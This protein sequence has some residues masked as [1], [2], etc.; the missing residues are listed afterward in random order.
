MFDRVWIVRHGETEWNLLRR[1][2]GQLDSPLTDRGRCQA[3]SAATQIPV[4]F[5]DGLFSSPL[6]RGLDTARVIAET[7]DLEITVIEELA[8]VHHGRFAGLTNAEIEARFPGELSRREL[9]KYCWQFPDGESYEQAAG[10]AARALRRISTIGV[11]RPILVTHEMIGRMLL[12]ELLD[13]HPDRAL[14][15][16]LPHG[17]AVTV[18]RAD[19]HYEMSCNRGSAVLWNVAAVWSS[20]SVP[21]HATAILPAT[22]PAGTAC[23]AGQNMAM[24][25]RSLR[26]WWKWTIIANLAG[27][28][29]LV[30][31]WAADSGALLVLGFI[32][33]VASLGVRIAAQLGSR[34]RPQQDRPRTRGSG[35]SHPARRTQHLVGSR[36]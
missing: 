28:A 34:R 2:Q 29:I 27:I 21:E 10:R 19:G 6:G 12:K 18:E 8:E 30:I 3:Q 15:A 17:E 35:R 4:G 16:S 14:L 25:A 33:L 1:R 31:G 22:V 20:E 26:T 32:V 13:L 9:I 7:L 36:R 11:R 23:P 5:A 24:T